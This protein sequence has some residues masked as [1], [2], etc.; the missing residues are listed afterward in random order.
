MD[1]EPD[2]LQ[3]PNTSTI[4]QIP[5]PLPLSIPLISSI[6]SSSINPLPIDEVC[7]FAKWSCFKIE[8]LQTMDEELFYPPS[9]P[10][11]FQIENSDESQKTPTQSAIILPPIPFRDF[12]LPTYLPNLIPGP[13]GLELPP[14]P[15]VQME[16]QPGLQAKFLHILS[17]PATKLH[18]LVC[19]IPTRDQF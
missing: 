5:T 19:N 2:D 17:R 12:S 15:S 13:T 6:S 9:P 10:S 7:E 8:C 18:L 4:G 16:Q 1:I 3:A 11:H 14:V